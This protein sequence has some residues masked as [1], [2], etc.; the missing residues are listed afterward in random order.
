MR[1]S[2]IFRAKT[3]D[4]SKFRCVH[5]DKGVRPA[6]ADKGEGKSVG[7]KIS[8]EG[9]R[10]NIENPG[11]ATAPPLPTPTGGGVTVSQICA[12]VLLGGL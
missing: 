5:T 2:A 9:Q 8:R 4:F 1:T 11:E 3:S 12:N 6:S 7:R 10:K